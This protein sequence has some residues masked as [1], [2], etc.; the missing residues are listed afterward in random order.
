MALILLRRSLGRLLTHFLRACQLSIVVFVGRHAALSYHRFRTEV[1]IKDMAGTT[2]LAVSA[3]D[4]TH[5][6]L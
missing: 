2:G 1:P 4:G 6:T 5:S 3:A